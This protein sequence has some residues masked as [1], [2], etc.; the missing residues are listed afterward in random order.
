MACVGRTKECTIVPKDHY[1]P[2]PGVEVGTCW[3]FR[4]QAS[5][6]GIHRPHVAGI[7]GRETDGAY[8]LVLSGGYEDDVDNG[9]EFYYTGSGGRDLSGNKRCAE[10]S[11]DQTL[12]RMNKALAMNCNAPFNN[13]EGAT[14]DDWK[15]G[16]PV[17]VVRN[18]KLSKH[19]K[20]APKDGNRYDGLYKVVKYYPEKG[21]SGFIVWRYLLRRD[22]QEPSPWSEKGKELEMIYP[23]GYIEA[24][25]KASTSNSDSEEQPKKKR[26]KVLT[27]QNDNSPPQKKHK[28]EPYVFSK[29]IKKYISSDREN[30]KLWAEC[31]EL[32]KAGKQE[33]LKKV[34][35]MFMCIC[36]QEVAF[37]PVTTECKHNVCKA[38]LK[39]SFA[40]EIYTCP[41]C[42]FN[43][44]SDYKIT[45]NENLSKALLGLLPGYENGR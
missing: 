3:K 12:T 1:G 34:Q 8:S 4:L 36:C 39:R 45:V 30:N 7:H 15:G 20:Y 9:E 31:N 42:R 13:K 10:Q 37:E 25:N 5:E 43:L 22:D 14:A 21:K 33:Y 44:G 19:S 11:C 41:H 24:Q 17:R 35:D 16:K 38:C 26:K 32:L 28:V 40:S 2:V 23:P 6:A 27:A 18:Y 29:T